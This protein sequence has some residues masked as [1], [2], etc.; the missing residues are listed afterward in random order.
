MTPP[1]P[2]PA[3]KASK[4]F[5]ADQCAEAL[6]DF[7][8]LASQAASRQSRGLP[9]LG[10]VVG[11]LERSEYEYHMTK[12]IYIY[13][14]TCTYIYIDIYSKLVLFLFVGDSCSFPAGRIPC[15]LAALVFANVREG[16]K[17]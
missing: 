15:R 16:P 12:H 13:V 5:S 4:T 17:P 9:Y 8:K 11:E 3:P 1:P 10:S 6:Q 2:L 14:G 7:V